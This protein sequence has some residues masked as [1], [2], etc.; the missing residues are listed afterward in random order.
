MTGIRAA[1]TRCVPEVVV[2]RRKVNSGGPGE[3]CINAGMAVE[4]DRL[5]CSF[6]VKRIQD[7]VCIGGKQGCSVAP[8]LNILRTRR[9]PGKYDLFRAVVQTGNQGEFRTTGNSCH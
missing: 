8:V 5:K 3:S 6:G 4:K 7:A 2:D 9:E 1:I